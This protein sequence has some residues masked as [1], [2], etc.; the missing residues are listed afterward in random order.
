MNDQLTS[1]TA[2]VIASF[3]RAAVAIIKCLESPQS[4]LLL[5]RNK[6][7]KDP[8]SNHYA[9]PGGRKEDQDVSLFATCVRETFEETGIALKDDLLVNELPPTLAGRNVKAPILVQPFLF[10]LA[11]RP[12]ITIE[13]AE[14]KS[15]V[16]LDVALFSDKN[17]HSIVEVYPGR[18][19]PVYHLE[20]YYVWGFTYGLLI[21]L[22]G[23]DIVPY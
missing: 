1:S 20:D 10:E 17:N 11:M 13:P 15:F 5:R 6:S 3:P 8:W 21:R 12:T 7:D 19:Y 18:D 16:W 14:I 4:I 23:L 22:F 2:P 9:L